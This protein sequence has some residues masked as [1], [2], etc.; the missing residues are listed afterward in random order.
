MNKEF[1]KRVLTSILLLTLLGLAFIYT[2]ILIISLIIMSITTWIEFNGLLSKILIKKK[3][4][5]NSLI[6]YLKQ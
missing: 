1:S 3:K 6:L 4:E 5:V 2:Y